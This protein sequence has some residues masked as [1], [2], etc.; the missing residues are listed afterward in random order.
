MRYSSCPEGEFWE[1][2]KVVA[3]GYYD[4]KPVPVNGC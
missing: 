2:G 1:M 3:S 4:I